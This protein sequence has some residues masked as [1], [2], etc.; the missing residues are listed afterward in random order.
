MIDHSFAVVVA[1]VALFVALVGNMIYDDAHS[2]FHT[3]NEI[4]VVDVLPALV[5]TSSSYYDHHSSL[6][7][8]VDLM[9]YA[10][11]VVE[12][13]IVVFV[14]TFHHHHLLFYHYNL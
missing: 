13:V 1:V 4:D 3:E 9:A 12:T 10:D 8:F 6:F 7:L 5:M 2:C 14:V 11:A